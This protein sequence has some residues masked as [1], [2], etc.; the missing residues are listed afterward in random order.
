[1]RLRSV[2]KKLSG[3]THGNESLDRLFKLAIW[4]ESPNR[5]NTVDA[6][7]EYE[8]VITAFIDGLCKN[9]AP[10]KILKVVSEGDRLLFCILT[11][12]H[13]LK[14]KRI[15]DYFRLL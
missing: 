3:S 6:M 2:Y 13:F 14:I 10:M 15:E 4:I 7:N 8:E 12:L 1:M 9:H 5:V 11:A